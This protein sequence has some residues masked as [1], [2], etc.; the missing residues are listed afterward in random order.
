MMNKSTDIYSIEY[1][2]PKNKNLGK[3]LSFQNKSKQS[4]YKV[5][6]QDNIEDRVYLVDA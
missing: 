5:L 3:K 1:Y 6:V 4:N 2:L